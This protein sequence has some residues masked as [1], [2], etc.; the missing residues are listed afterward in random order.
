LFAVRGCSIRSTGRYAA[1]FERQPRSASSVADS[2]G[3]AEPAQ[4]VFGP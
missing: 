2:G 4:D 1:Q 3:S